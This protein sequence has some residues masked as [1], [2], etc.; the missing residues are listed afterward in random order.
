MMN[1]GKGGGTTGGELRHLYYGHC[2]TAGWP[3]FSS[4]A[5]STPEG[6]TVVVVLNEAQEDV[7][8]L[9]LLKNGHMQF[10]TSIP[11]SSIQT[12]VF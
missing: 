5:F 7:P 11:V 6:E 12:Y 10:N 3:F 1:G 2:L 8:F 9:V 4:V